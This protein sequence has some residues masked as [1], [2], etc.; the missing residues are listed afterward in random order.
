VAVT[1]K[2]KSILSLYSR[3]GKAYRA[4]NPLVKDTSG[5]AGSAVFDDWMLDASS[6]AVTHNVTSSLVGNVATVTASSVHSVPH[7][8]TSGLVGGGST[9]LA[10]SVHNVPHSVTSGLLSGGSSLSGS[11]DRSTGSVTHG[12]TSVLVGDVSTLTGSA[13]RTRQHAVTSVLVGDASSLT[14]TSVH[15]AVH[16]VTSGLVGAGSTLVAS[17][18]RAGAAVVHDVVSALVGAG[19]D[20]TSLSLKASQSTK[21]GG[22]DAPRGIY[23]QDQP[24]RKKRKKIGKILDKTIEDK[25]HALTQTTK[26]VKKK[27]E[28]IVKPFKKAKAIDWESL[29]ADIAA[30]EALL[31]LYQGFIGQQDEEDIALLL[32]MI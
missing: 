7:A 4:I 14:A 16:A 15:S 27:A 26:V 32:L 2:N 11:A 28:E 30:V 5:E 1:G 20:L 6:G 31:M 22:D 29:N 18:A 3:I 19:S 10:T 24:A 25:Y 17:V 8:V 12:V 21:V 9:L 23:Y 13:N